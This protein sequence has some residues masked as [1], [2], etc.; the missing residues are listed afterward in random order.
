MKRIYT[1]SDLKLRIVNIKGIAEHF[2][3]R[4]YT[5]NK[6]IYIEKTDQDIIFDQQLG[7]VLKLNWSE[8]ALIGE[9]VLNYT[10]N[11]K[12]TDSDY[13]DGEYNLTLSGTT[14]YYIDSNVIID[15]DEPE[16]SILEVIADLSNEMHNKDNE[17]ES[18]LQGCED[19]YMNLSQSLAMEQTARQTGDSMIWDSVNSTQSNLNQLTTRLQGCEDDYM[20]LSQSL[21]MEQTARQTG[22]SMLWNSMNSTQGNLNLL[23]DDFEYE[24]NARKEDD[25]TLESQINTKANSADVYTKAE[26]DAMIADLVAQIQALQQ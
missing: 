15:D 3:I 21:A 6:T 9:G 24:R 26:V 12:V 7:K 25:A 23:R 1:D 2:A 4:F 18:R 8:L 5:T 11:N 22:D 13:S 16:T 10:I 17:L 20:N 14:E 19:D